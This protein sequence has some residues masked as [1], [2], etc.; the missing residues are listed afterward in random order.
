MPQSS[1]PVAPAPAF[2]AA[3]SGGGWRVY[4]RVS[5]R[6]IDAPG[7]LEARAAAAVLSGRV[8]AVSLRSI[9]RAVD[10]ADHAGGA[11]PEGWYLA[12][13]DAERAERGV[14][15]AVFVNDAELR[16]LLLV[17]NGEHARALAEVVWALDVW[18]R[19]TEAALRF[20]DALP[21]SGSL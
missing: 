2:T 9:V 10:D 15:R 12:L 5:G 8:H 6:S 16:A 14:A 11:A 1:V 7:E 17:E 3:R 4:E 21:S 20:V 18:Y 13:A 19:A